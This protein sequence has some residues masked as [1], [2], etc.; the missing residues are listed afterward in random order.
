M[1]L[2]SERKRELAAEYGAGERDTGNTKVQIAQ[3][4][5]RINGLTQHLR[6]HRNDHHSRRGLLML[7]GQRR[8]FL[9]YLRKTDLERYRTLIR[10]LGLRR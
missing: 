10:E 5:E 9:N 6:E 8:R 7:N 4:T 1:T 2:T 3:L